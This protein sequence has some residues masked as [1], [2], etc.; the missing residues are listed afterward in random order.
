MRQ[1]SQATTASAAHGTALMQI[2]RSH[3]RRA[4]PDEAAESDGPMV[5]ARCNTEGH[6]SEY[7]ARVHD[8]TPRHERTRHAPRF[9]LGEATTDVRL[10]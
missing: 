8:V 1:N 7:A 2:A 10:F 9:G 3:G 6:R 5:F 4:L